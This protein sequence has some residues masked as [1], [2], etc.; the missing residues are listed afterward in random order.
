MSGV[1]LTFN[2]TNVEKIDT[3]QWLTAVKQ[4]VASIQVLERRQVHEVLAIS[5]GW[6]RETLFAA[7]QERIARQ[8]VWWH[9]CTERSCQIRPTVIAR[10]WLQLFE[11][12]QERNQFARV[13]GTR[14]MHGHVTE[15]RG[16]E[17]TVALESLHRRH[18]LVTRV[19]LHRLLGDTLTRRC[20]I[21]NGVQH[22][23]DLFDVLFV[24]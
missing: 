13:G 21:A 1:A 10:G 15:W 11:L 16:H 18:G 8:N 22:G 3:R 19:N 2:F 4:R 23:S 5:G 7:V 9:G 20:H 17:A 24:D 14:L 12:I 6:G